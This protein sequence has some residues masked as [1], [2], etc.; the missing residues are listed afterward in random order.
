MAVKEK[1]R[2]IVKD[3]VALLAMP[4]GEI[5]PGQVFSRIT[6][7]LGQ[8]PYAIIKVWVKLIETKDV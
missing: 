8:Q 1:C 4:N 6:D 2:V 7:S 5:I 3:G